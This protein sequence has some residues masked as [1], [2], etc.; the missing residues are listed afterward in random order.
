MLRNLK[1]Y[2][3]PTRIEDAVALITFEGISDLCGEFAIDEVVNFQDHFNIILQLFRKGI[4]FIVS[5][6]L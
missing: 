3:R 5:V 4:L 6:R 1:H 2:K